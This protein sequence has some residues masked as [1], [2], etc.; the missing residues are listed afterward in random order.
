MIGN[1]RVEIH[2]L[3]KILDVRPEPRQVSVTLE[4]TP[5]ALEALKKI[6]LDPVTEGL[7]LDDIFE[8]YVAGKPNT[9]IRLAPQPA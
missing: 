5:A 4:N 6:G 3:T 8:A 9:P 7:N 2:G 1:A